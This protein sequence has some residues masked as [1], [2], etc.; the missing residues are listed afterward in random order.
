MNNEERLEQIEKDN[1]ELKEKIDFL[2]FRIELVASKTHVNQVLYDY[3]V[4]RKQYNEIMD[5][6]D[7]VQEKLNNNKKYDSSMFENDLKKIFCDTSD[8]KHDY[9]FAEEIAQ[10]FMKDERWEKVFPKLYGNHK[11]YQ[12]YIESLRNGEK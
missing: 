8:P 9:H 1:E 12:Y 3:E 7:N 10:A 5:L 2:E 6:M 11:K 4:N